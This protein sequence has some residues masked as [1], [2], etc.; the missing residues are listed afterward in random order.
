MPEWAKSKGSQR[1]VLSAGELGDS[2]APLPEGRWFGGNHFWFRSRVLEGRRRFKDVWLTEPDFQLDLLELGFCTLIS[3][4]TKCGH[5]IQPALLQKDVAMERAKRFGVAEARL[6]VLPYREKVKQ[7]RQLR[8]HPWLGG[9]YC[10][11]RFLWWCG[12][13]VS[14]YFFSPDG[15]GFEQ[16]LMATYRTTYYWELLRAAARSGDY[17]LWPSAGKPEVRQTA[18][19]AAGAKRS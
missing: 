3:P 18:D 1:L 6:R 12:Q 17:S 10:L 9:T 2:E 8:T 14:S 5:R 19:I 15:N 4:K 13:Y 11:V 7:A 16:R